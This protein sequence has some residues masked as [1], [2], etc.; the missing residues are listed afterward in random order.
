MRNLRNLLVD[1]TPISTV[2]FPKILRVTSDSMFMSSAHP[3]TVCDKFRSRNKVLKSLSYG[4]WGEDKETMFTTYKVIGLSVANFA[5][6]VCD[7]RNIQI[8]QN[9]ALRTAI[10]CRVM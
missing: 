1:N 8:Y 2:S 6:P 4:T 10:G 9:A 7:R 3:T 5:A